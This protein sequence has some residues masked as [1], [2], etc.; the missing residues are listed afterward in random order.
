[1]T[2]LRSSTLS[3]TG[4]LEREK[5]T[6]TEEARKKKEVED[7]DEDMGPGGGG[8]ENRASQECKDEKV[9]FPSWREEGA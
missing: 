8:E 5:K 6:K 2:G 1:M 4:K 7:D 9:G 3:E